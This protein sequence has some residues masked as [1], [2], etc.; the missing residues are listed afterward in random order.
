MEWTINSL[1]EWLDPTR[2]SHCV[3]RILAVDRPSDSAM[4]IEV[5][6]EAVDRPSDSAL[7]MEVTKKAM[8]FRR[9]CSEIE[10]AI[11]SGGA[12]IQENDPWVRPI[13]FDFDPRHVAIRDRA[14]EIIGPIVS[15]K[16]PFSKKERAA[17]IR[18]AS[19]LTTKRL[20]YAHLR[21]YWQGGQTKNALLPKYE[22][23]GAK[24]NSRTAGKKPG[25][26]TSRDVPGKTLTDEDRKRMDAGINLYF[27]NG[28]KLTLKEAYKRTIE[29]FYHSGYEIGPT[30][31][32]V[33]VLLPPSERPSWKQFMYHHDQME[34]LVN[35]LINRHG[36][37][38]FNLKYRPITGRHKV[39]CPGKLYLIDS[40]RGDIHL[41]SSTDPTQVIGRPT[42]IVVVDAF[43]RLI[44]GIHITL[45]EE[46]YENL[47]KAIENAARNKVE[48][49]YDYGITITPEQ[50]PAHHLPEGILADRG[51]LRGPI[52]NN[53]VDTLHVKLFNTPPCRGDYKGIIE[54]TFGHLNAECLS[55]L[56]GYID[57]N[58]TR[59][60]R[61]PRQKASLN[62]RDFTTLVILW[63][64]S[65]NAA[66]LNYYRPDKDTAN[67][68]P[69]PIALWRWGIQNRS[70]ALRTLPPAYVKA[71]LLLKGTAYL[72]RRG[73][74]FKGY[75]YTCATAVEKQWFVGANGIRQP[76]PCHYDPSDASRIYISHE[77][78]G[79][80]ECLL[81][82]QDS[83][84]SIQTREELEIQG[85]RIAQLKA[86]AELDAERSRAAL[87]ATIAAIPVI[88]G[89]R[90]IT[91]T[92]RAKANEIQ[93]LKTVGAAEQLAS[94]A[95]SKVINLPTS[96]AIERRNRRLLE[97]LNKKE[98]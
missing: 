23:C 70:G 89:R 34:N 73:I 93:L 20:V 15:I 87:N 90:K 41:V 5:A 74:S 62:I 47:A 98:T 39:F 60:D 66:V 52:A 35:T 3:E 4:V 51:P 37:K 10:E 82:D 92:D 64:L 54:R 76:V 58:Y 96:S 31:A 28:E 33:P 9:T 59:G 86:G 77:A 45:G 63:V 6:K 26:K 55:K 40:T 49:C 53:I 29:K 25:P 91:D 7:V 65:K 83:L 11:Q 30:G 67:V 48:F 27:E 21:R 68:T 12:S 32:P 24:G 43:S 2:R 78:S 1:I 38:E 69:I 14:W 17:A 80:D 88:Q 44:V 56:P 94:P 81:T 85:A 57:K 18:V 13:P 75:Y 50:W 46:S 36:E 16:N 95:P 22:E 79:F 97:M 8:P 72:T 42:I 19:K 84:A 71:A 61:D